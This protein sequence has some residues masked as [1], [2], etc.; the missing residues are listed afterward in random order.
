MRL[1]IITAGETCQ[2]RCGPANPISYTV[3]L[4]DTPKITLLCTNC[5][6]ISSWPLESV[7]RGHEFAVRQSR[8]HRKMEPA[9]NLLSL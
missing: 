5:S 2:L 9:I 8:K 6:T 4:T 1:V 7:M 3:K